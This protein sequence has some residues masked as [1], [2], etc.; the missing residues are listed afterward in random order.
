[1]IGETIWGDLPF[2]EAIA[3]F[4]GQIPMTMDQF[5]MLSDE[6]RARAFSVSNVTGIDA[7]KSMQDSLSKALEEGLT[8]ADWQAL[9]GDILSKYDI[10]GAL[11]DT[12]FRTN[13]QTAYQ[14]GHYMQMSDPDVVKERPFWRYVAVMD[15]RTRPEHAAWHDTVLPTDDPWWDTHYPPNGYNCR[16]T[17]VSMSEA[18]LERSGLPVSPSPKI[19]YYEYVDKRTG[20]VREVPKGIDPGFDSN[21]A[22]LG[23]AMGLL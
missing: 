6:A 18:G 14:A 11:A 10:G 4:R 23:M 17:V 12:I 16:C 21:P 20:E 3:F 7:L 19:E 5:L 2:D 13:L 15:E 9:A 1:M 8:F 22:K